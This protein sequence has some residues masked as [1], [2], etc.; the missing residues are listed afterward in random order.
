MKVTI[1]CLTKFWAFQLAH[2]LDKRGYLHKLITTYYSNKPMLL[3]R[4][5][6]DTEKISLSK[7]KTN[8]VPAIL[9]NGFNKVPFLNSL[10]NWNYYAL[11]LF[12]IWAS[13]SLDPTDIVMAWSAS[14]L[15]T[16]RKAKLLGAK[17]V[18][19]R[20]STHIQFQKMILEEEYERYNVKSQPVDERI[21]QKELEEYKECDYIFTPSDFSAQSY[22]SY[23]VSS[24]KIIHIPFGADLEMFK[25]LPKEDDIFRVIYCGGITLRKG[26]QYLI[27]A[28][29][30]LKLPKSE[31]WL[32]GGINQ[33][34][35]QFLRINRHPNII[36]KGKQLQSS[37]SWFYSQCNVFC[38]ASIEEGLATVIPQAMACGLPIICTTNTGG[39]DI[40]REGEEGFILPIRNIEAIKEKILYLYENEELRK[41]MSENALKRAQEFTWDICGNKIIEQYKKIIK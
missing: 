2:Q 35:K 19:E 5:R 36:L 26:I 14:A 25:P 7:V 22:I 27:R 13:D 34:I 39:A 18:L 6:N 30:E 32:V 28:F 15:R 16:I 11:E 41:H 33:D 1:S 29:N 10:C 24:S 21:V 17:T 40:V 12:D 23:G 4:L 3:P 8:L 37:L 9:N 31:L 38:I 20:G